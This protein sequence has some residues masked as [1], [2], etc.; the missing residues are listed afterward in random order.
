MENS[1]HIL[2]TISLESRRLF[3]ELADELNFNLETCGL[4][5]LCQTE[6]G[7]EEEAEVASMAAEVGVQAEVCNAGRVREFDPEVRM[8]VV[9]GVWF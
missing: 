5:M 2:S 6:A 9:G 3:L 1:K 4:M 8:D 7:L